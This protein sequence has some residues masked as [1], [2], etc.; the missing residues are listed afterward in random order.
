MT[1]VPIIGN[2][3]NIWGNVLNDYI[4]KMPYFNVLAYDADPT[5]SSDSTVAVANAMSAAN[6]AGGGTAFFP[7][8]TFS[9]TITLCNKVHILGAG[10]E[11][12]IIKLPNGANAD[13]VS[14][15]TGS[16]DLSASFGSGSAGGIHDWSIQDL[17]LDGNKSNQ[18]SGTSYCLRAYAYSYL[19][20]N[21]YITN[22][23]T[24]GALLDWNGGDINTGPEVESVLS[25]VKI[26]DNNGAGLQFGGPHDTMFSK[27][28]IMRNGTHGIHV[29]QNAAG[30]QFTSCHSWGPGSG[31][32]PWLIDAGFG[33]YTS[34]VAEGA[35]SGG[36]QVV[37]KNGNNQWSGLIFG[38][39]AVDVYGLQLGTS[40]GGGVAATGSLIN[41]AIQDCNNG[42]LNFANDGGGNTIRA[43]IY[44]ATS[45]ATAIAG[46]P[47]ASTYHDIEVTG[48]TPD[49]TLA[50]GG[51]VKWPISANNAILVTDGTNDKFTLSTFYSTL[52]LPNAMAIKI[53]SDN[54]STL[55]T[56]INADGA[57]SII[58][59]GS[60]QAGDAHHISS[61]HD[62]TNATISTDHG[63]ILLQPETGHS[64]KLVSTNGSA[65][66]DTYG[67]LFLSA[68]INTPAGL[69]LYGDP[70][71]HA[72]SNNGTI[73]ALGTARY[74]AAPSANVTG[75]IMQAGYQGQITEIINNSSFTITF[76]AVGTS[77]VADG[78]SAVIAAKR[79]MHLVYNENDLLWYH[80]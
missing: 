7:A 46:T 35:T 26:Y 62:G 36:T 68:G 12:T 23:Y 52:H 53:W 16:I 69:Y 75:I 34:C 71:P 64:I 50:K 56:S 66:I 29:A 39:G 78:T 76:A 21:L 30:V 6:S 41:V 55:K 47:N 59:K 77:N 8:G 9:C 54:Y 74:V 73:S 37:L 65:E 63:D 48:I 70:T 14:A 80:S 24:G 2:D 72:L 40:G 79:V 67:N 42:H 28:H 58:S 49:G 15:N 44:S 25:N 17:T 51:G 60:I 5:G 31:G 32:N 22:G 45:G 19:L 33:I 3:S 10:T 11:A 38:A 43:R 27:M 20:Q 4:K 13:L 1:R 61:S 18:S 57:G